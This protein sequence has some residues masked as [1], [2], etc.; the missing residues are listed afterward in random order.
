M[1][2][3]TVTVEGTPYEVTL[4]S[5]DGTSL[6]FSVE[7][8]DY[9]VSVATSRDRI[10]NRH[11]SSLSAAPTPPPSTAT[12]SSLSSQISGAITAPI[13]GIVSALKVSVGDSVAKGDTVAIIEA[14]KME[15]PI[16]ALSAGVVKELA[17]QVGDEVPAGKILVQLQ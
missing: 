2:R 8:T 13:P 10:K 5:K 7:G 1:N 4:L 6:S 11:T 3:Y 16:R 12:A 15:N 17:V 14:M 9:H